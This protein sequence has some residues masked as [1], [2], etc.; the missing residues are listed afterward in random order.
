MLPSDSG[1]A[2]LVAVVP[3]DPSGFDRLEA[4]N[5]LLA[6]LHGRAIPRDTRLT[7]QQKARLRRVLQASDAAF[8]GAT[9]K[10]IAEVLFRTGKLSR[11]E[12]QVASSRF[13]I[14]SLLREAREMIAGGYRRLLRH[15]RRF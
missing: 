3:L 6:S 13:A 10:Q 14:S 4:V 2:P 11:D 7:W 9:Q 8:D 5:R 12:W 1:E 15:H